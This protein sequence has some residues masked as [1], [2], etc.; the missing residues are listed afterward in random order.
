MRWTM[1]KGALI[2]S[3]L[4][5]TV[6]AD[7]RDCSTSKPFHLPKTQKLSGTFR[8]PGGAVVPGIE[9]HLLSGK[10]VVRRVR[11]DIS[12]AYDFGEVPSGTYKIRVK[13]APKDAFCA[14]EIRCVGEQCT[15]DSTLKPNPKNM[16]YVE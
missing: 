11:T 16:V 6:F 12:G 13:Y 2:A 15:I 4:M 14:P 8:D 1:L 7:A 10:N 5:M 3:T 9:V